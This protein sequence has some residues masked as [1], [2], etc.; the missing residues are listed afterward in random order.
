MK[1][2]FLILLIILST[3]NIK[4]YENEYFKIDIPDNYK[5]EFLENDSYKWTNDNKYI[6]IT[7]SNNEDNNYDISKFTN[8]D[9]LNQEQYIEENIN[10]ELVEHNIKVDVTNIKLNEL[11]NNTSLTYEVYWPTNELTGHDIYQLGS[12]YT[13]S[14]YIITIIYNSDEKID[15]NNEEFTTLLNSLTIKDEP[16]NKFNNYFY[17]IILLIFIIIIIGFIIINKKH[18]K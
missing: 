3:I 14:N 4:A 18:K 12:T 10:K 17:T 6:A 9:I 11:N 2:I 5:E 15:S 8:D 1:K 7:I 16:I 13:T